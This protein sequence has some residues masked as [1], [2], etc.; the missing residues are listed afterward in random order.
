MY[1]LFIYNIIHC[2]IDLFIHKVLPQALNTMKTYLVGGAV[3]DQILGIAYTEKDWVVVGASIQ[4]MRDQDFRQVGQHFPVFIHPHSQEEYALARTERKTAPGYHGFEFNT[5]PHVTLEEDLQRRDLT[6]N[7]IAQD[8]AGNLIDPWGG[9][10]DIEQRILRHVSDAFIEDP[11]RI[12]RAA[13]FRS[14]FH[15]LDFTLA[16]ETLEM[17]RAMVANGEADHLVAERVWKETEKVLS[18][19]SPSQFFHTLAQVGLLQKAFPELQGILDNPKTSAALCLDHNAEMYSPAVLFAVLAFKAHP[20]G[21]SLVP[22]CQRLKIPRLYLRVARFVEQV[23]D[24]LAHSDA[25]TAKALLKLL[26]AGNALR[27][28]DEF[29]NFLLAWV[30]TGG[31]AAVVKRL[32]QA[33]VA[34][35]A[36]DFK[37]V[38]GESP[39]KDNIA[40]QVREAQLNAIKDI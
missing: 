6:V 28:P 4:D 31:N 18:G 26:D 36:I 34:L 40:R 2:S 16:A 13:R 14:K 38:L 24:D 5:S 25:L 12:L 15:S 22:L 35:Q 21:Q 7:A 10:G 27:K 17:M 11:V 19:P 3:R 30:L 37:E 9:M 32:H 8:A 20:Q 1:L 33:T 29:N 39:N 23:G